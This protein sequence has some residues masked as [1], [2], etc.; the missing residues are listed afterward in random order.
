MMDNYA[1]D[2]EL[3]EN[4]KQW[5][6]AN[7]LSIIIG[8]AIGLAAIFGWRYWHSYQGHQAEAA[9]QR[10]EALSQA[11]ETG[12]AAEANEQ[13]E[14]L[15]KEFSKSPYTVLA[16]LQLAR[17]AVEEG[18][19][20]VAAERL[21]WALKH[22]DRQELK[23]IARLRLARVLLAL[24]QLAEAETQLEQV[25]SAVFYAEREEI[26]GDLYLARDEPDKARVAYGAALAAQ[27]PAGQNALLQMKLD[28]LPPPPAGGQ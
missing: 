23:D 17:L 9:S 11:I 22:A 1:S 26:K 20:A 16:M 12:K 10:Y 5:W 14:A 4:I 13:G 25:N 18:D 6:K 7:G 28:N 21:R 19:N 3:V 8:L 24:N 27:G 15:V 2:E